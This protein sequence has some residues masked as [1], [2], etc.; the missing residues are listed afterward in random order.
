MG[1]GRGSCWLDFL[2]LMSFQGP[3]TITKL[4]SGQ[5]MIEVE[6]FVGNNMITITFPWVPAV[7]MHVFCPNF[8][9]LLLYLDMSGWICCC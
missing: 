4:V 2:S 8:T 7:D 1:L 6:V 9:C 3:Q 5:N